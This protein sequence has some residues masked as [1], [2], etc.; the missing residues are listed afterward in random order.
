MSKTYIGT[1]YSN[2]NGEFQHGIYPIARCLKAEQH[3]LSVVEVINLSERVDMRNEQE[4][5]LGRAEQSRAEQK[6]LGSL[7]GEKCGAGYAGCVWDKNGISPTLMT[8]QGGGRQPHILEVKKLEQQIVAMRGR[9]TTCLSPKRTEYGKEI[10]KA[11]E[12]HEI[13]EQRKNMQQLE[14]RTDGLTN[15]ITTIT[16]DNMLLEVGHYENVVVNDRGFVDKEPQISENICPTLRSETHGNELKVICVNKIV[17]GNIE[18]TDIAIRLELD[19]KFHNFVYDVDGE[20]YLI[21]IRKLIPKECFRLMGFSD[22][23]FEKAAGVVSNSQLY[24]IAGNS[25]A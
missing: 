17:N 4:H 13:E 10:R 14:P 9:E 19:E 12:N 21:R 8:M 7:Y 6:F 23:D 16:K 3:D 5:N 2:Q 1:L 18:Q 24:K 25:I 11:Y 22:E 15:T 20:L